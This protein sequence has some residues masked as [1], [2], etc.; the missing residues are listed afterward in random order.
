M[1]LIFVFKRFELNVNSSLLQK[2][3]HNLSYLFLQFTQPSLPCFWTLSTIIYEVYL[4]DWPPVF[5]DVS[6]SSFVGLQRLTTKWLHL[7][8]QVYS[9]YK[10][11]SMTKKLMMWRDEKAK[12]HFLTHCDSTLRRFLILYHDYSV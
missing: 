9:H 4:T 1:S 11:A 10:F 3:L 6:L 8:N 7:N 12:L 5:N 2:L